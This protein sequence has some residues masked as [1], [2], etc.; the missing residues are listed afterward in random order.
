MNPVEF[1]EI[2]HRNEKIRN[3][4]ARASFRLEMAELERLWAIVTAHNEG[5]SIREI[6]KQVG[7]GPTR[8]HQIV[9]DPRANLVE[10]TISVLRAVGWP[11]PEDPLTG[12]GHQVADRI[13]EEA[14]LL[15]TCATWLE[16][17]TSGQQPVVNLRPDADL[18][19]SNCTIVDHARIIRMLR[20]IAHDLEELARARRVEDLTSNPITMEARQ[21]RRHQLCEPPITPP[22][23]RPNILQARCAWEEYEIRL[24]KAGL[25]IPDNPYRHL[26]RSAK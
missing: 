16:K 26:D 8:V 22:R 1:R 24:R 6:A 3:R 7:L 19:E 25:P 21:F 10:E 20:R 5:L 4:L 11:S 18:P 13:G 17:L 14:A 2:I 9:S 23:P 15:I 12:D